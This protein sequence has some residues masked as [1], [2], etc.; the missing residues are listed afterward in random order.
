MSPAPPQS[1]LFPVFTHPWPPPFHSSPPFI[2]SCCSQ[3]PRQ[4]RAPP[5]PALCIYKES[6]WTWPL[7]FLSAGRK[8]SRR[9]RRASSWPLLT[10]SSRLTRGTGLDEP[11][12]FPFCLW[13]KPLAGQVVGS[14]PAIQPGGLR[15]SSCLSLEVSVLA[16][17]LPGFAARTNRV[18]HVGLPPAP[19]CHRPSAGEGPG[20]RT[21][22]RCL[23][24]ARRLLPSAYLGGSAEPAG[25]EAGWQRHAWKTHRCQSLWLVFLFQLFFPWSGALSDNW[26]TVGR[27]PVV[28]LAGAGFRRAPSASWVSAF[29]FRDARSPVGTGPSSRMKKLR[30]WGCRLCMGEG[31][32]TARGELG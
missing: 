8:Q 21:R 19:P 14:R 23:F 31:R 5:R 7:G 25:V 4:F 29:V 32:V 16:R 24:S 18:G 12:M 30:P 27:L 28:I 1:P 9:W 10:Q 26:R 3:L 20:R 22:A 13:L 15:A 11:F 6:L 2:D 17:A